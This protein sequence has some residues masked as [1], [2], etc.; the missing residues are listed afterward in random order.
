M[1]KIAVN[2]SDIIVKDE[3]KFRVI[4]CAQGKI[5]LCCIDTSKLQI[6]LAETIDIIQ[7][8]ENK[9]YELIP[10][11]SQPKEVFDMQTLTDEQRDLYQRKVEFVRQICNEYG[12]LY[13]SLTGRHSKSEFKKFAEAAKLSKTVS[14]KTVRDYLQSGFDNTSLIDRR[15]LRESNQSYVYTK[16]TGRPSKNSLGVGCALTEDV[17]AKMEIARK[18][19]LSGREKSIQ[20]T[21]TALIR[22]YY[23]NVK[24]TPSGVV[25]EPV[26]VNMRP[27]YKQLYLYIT[28]NSTAK[29]IRVS[30]TSAQEYRN[31]ERMLLSDNL[32]GVSGPGSLFE[33]DE[34][35][36]DVS[37]VSEINPSLTVGRPIVYAMVDVYSRMIVAVSIAFDNNS[38]KGITNLFLNLLDDKQEWM[39]KYDIKIEKD[40]MPSHII[41]QRIRSDYGSEYIS[42][43]MERIGKE[44]G[45]QME[46]ASPG[47]GSLKGQIEQLFHQIHSA[48]NP[49]LESHGLIEKRHD[50][51]HHKEATLTIKEVTAMVL[52]TVAVHNRK[53]MEHYPLDAQMIKEHVT[54]TPVNLWKYGVQ[55][56]GAPRLINNEDSFRYSMLI[57][58]S[59][60]ISKSGIKYKTLYYMN[61][62]DSG[63]L[64]KMQ[65]LKNR[66][67]KFD[68]RIDP[69]NVENVYYLSDNKLLTA[70]LNMNKK[71]M[72][73]YAGISLE[74]YEKLYQEKKDADRAGKENN[75][76]LEIGLQDR[77]EAIVKKAVK[78]KTA[79]SDPKNLSA[80][81]KAEKQRESL[82]HMVVPQNTSDENKSSQTNILDAN[83]PA[84]QSALDSINDVQDALAAF[85]EDEWGDLI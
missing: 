30:K 13:E 12:P 24:E 68:C 65:S 23:V 37:M 25:M 9:D 17:L 55:V 2:I 85:E 27:S 63:L 57:P 51:K 66:S 67:D 22:E 50:S 69:R 72:S 16:K 41:P 35:E 56:Y 15:L 76:K 79:P 44:L 78:Q 20:S 70:P 45:I 32:N 33:V 39:L 8:V 80:N 53:Y 77:H 49:S 60:R 18:K 43:N 59:A 84:S 34:C 82:N 61:Y 54:P 47:T 28:S 10:F 36:L 74:D 40:E 14:W 46:L 19:Y 62:N 52:A 1:E 29:E 71:G 26:P 42:Y 73:D 64:K 5:S 48:Q 75:L 6:S 31:S 7:H 4:G 38:F 83:V 11:T 81:R 21:Y 58:I 3:V